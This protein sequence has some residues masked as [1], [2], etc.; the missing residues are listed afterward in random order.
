[1]KEVKNGVYT[2]ITENGEE[3]YNFNFY[4]DLSVANKLNFVNSVV[5]ILVDESHYNS[6]IRDLIFD[7]YIVYMMT[8][9][10]DAK[11]LSASDAFLDDVE[12][13]L[14]YTNIVD[15]VKANVNPLLLDELNDAIDKSVQYLTGI[16]SSPFNDAIASLI[17]T[18]NRKID[19]IDLDVLIEMAKKF[20]NMTEDFTLENAINAYMNSD[21]HN[22]NLAEIIEYKNAHQ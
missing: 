7:F 1:M 6:V 12:Q 5:G 15:I 19:G 18:I 11:E 2:R 16:H 14:E 3:A 20:V 21:V 9:V 4:T 8:D 10:S 17:Y 13:F 22:N